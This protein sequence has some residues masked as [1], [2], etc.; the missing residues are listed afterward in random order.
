MIWLLLL[1]ACEVRVIDN[2]ALVDQLPG[3]SLGPAAI[4]RRTGRAR[5]QHLSQAADAGAADPLQ[6]A[7]GESAHA[8]EPFR[9]QRCDV[10]LLDLEVFGIDALAQPILVFQQECVAHLVVQFAGTV[11][12]T[13]TQQTHAETLWCHEIED[14][15]GEVFP[16]NSLFVSNRVAAMHDELQFVLLVKQRVP[17]L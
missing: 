4:G 11:D 9:L 8:D 12:V 6:A 17:S 7:G 16:E 3:G 10:G 5:M 1:T 13:D 2:R 14:S 15:I